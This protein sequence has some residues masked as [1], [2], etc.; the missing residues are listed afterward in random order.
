MLQQLQRMQSLCGGMLFIEVRKTQALP[1]KSVMHENSRSLHH[2]ANAEVTHD[3]SFDD[4]LE[5]HHPAN[6]Y[7]L[8]RSTSRLD[9]FRGVLWSN[10]SVHDVA[11][12]GARRKVHRGGATD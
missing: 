7:V 8:S 1:N 12:L 3:T 11:T 4:E 6:E 9:C 2:T 10:E 5:E